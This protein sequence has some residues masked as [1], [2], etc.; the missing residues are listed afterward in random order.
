M[1]LWLRECLQPLART[2]PQIR[3]D[4]KQIGGGFFSATVQQA[5]GRVARGLSQDKQEAIARARRFIRRDHN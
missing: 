2:E 4:V 1:T 3:V 5:R